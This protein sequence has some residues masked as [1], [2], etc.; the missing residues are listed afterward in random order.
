MSPVPLYVR[1]DKD[2]LESVP[3]EI[4]RIPSITL[5]LPESKNAPALEF[6]A[7]V[8]YT[9]SDNLLLRS[10][11]RRH[12]VDQVWSYDGGIEEKYN[13]KLSSDRV[14]ISDCV[15]FTSPSLRMPVIEGKEDAAQGSLVASTNEGPPTVTRLPFFYGQWS[16]SPAF[17]VVDQLSFNSAIESHFVAILGRKF[18]NRYGFFTVPE[19]STWAIKVPRLLRPSDSSIRVSVEGYCEVTSQPQSSTTIFRDL[20][21]MRPRAPAPI[22]AGYGIHCN[23]PG[24]RTLSAPLKNQLEP[25]THRATLRGIEHALRTLYQ[26]GLSNR[27]IQLR[28]SV[29][30]VMSS[31]YEFVHR[32]QTCTW[33]STRFLLQPSRECNSLL[34]THDRLDEDMLRLVE[35]WISD[36][37][38][39]GSSVTVVPVRQQDNARAKELAIHGAHASLVELWDE[40]RQRII[41][42]AFEANRT[43]LPKLR[44]GAEMRSLVSSDTID[45][46]GLKPY[47]E[48]TK[49]T[50]LRMDDYF[51]VS[52]AYEYRAE[53]RRL[54]QTATHSDEI[55]RFDGGY[56]GSQSVQTAPNDPW[57][58]P[59]WAGHGRPVDGGE[60]PLVSSDQTNMGLP[61]RGTEPFAEAAEPFVRPMEDYINIFAIEHPPQH[62]HGTADKPV[63][64]E[65]A[66][67]EHDILRSSQA[68]AE[69]PWDEK[70]FW[71]A[72]YQGLF[73]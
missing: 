32:L 9:T 7:I 57:H 46:N 40:P 53:Q 5:V 51:E 4:H 62:S 65:D 35:W 68:A 66:E 1:L 28:L 60:R 8:S 71:A 55:F 14:G 29:V 31:L 12:V 41:H 54:Q 45:L 2:L 19:E 63:V 64:I 33:D 22:K 73:S 36:L 6:K 10:F 48:Q 38:R 50:I 37:V 59:P 67:D 15:F 24:F 34:E 16:F 17:L 49:P 42:G 25:T 43:R 21:D 18:F 13:G 61:F 47:D 72:N 58:H 44:S 20:S 23:I 26:H 56:G 30:N 39:M 70:A 3:S 52:E 11:H 69:E 27:H